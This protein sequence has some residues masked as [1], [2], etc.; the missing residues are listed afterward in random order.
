AGAEDAQNLLRIHRALGELLADLDV[1]AVGDQQRH[2]LGDGVRDR[3]R[4]VVRRD[5]DLA[6]LV[7]LLDLDTTRELGDRREAGR[8][9]GLEQ[10]LHTRQTVRDV[11]VGAGHTTGVE[12]THGQLGAG[13]T[14]R[15]GRDDAD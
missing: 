6:L 10:L 2:A 13:L 3:V 15:L 9:A 8:G 7:V 1:V 14:D 4:A 12:G 11:A 5:R